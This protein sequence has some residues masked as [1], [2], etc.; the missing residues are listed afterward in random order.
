M[1]NTK[2]KFTS[3]CSTNGEVF[4]SI[5]QAIATTE[6]CFKDICQ[7]NTI[8]IEQVYEISKQDFDALNERNAKFGGKATY[9]DGVRVEETET[10]ND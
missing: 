4:L 9:H 1:E 7:P 6:D 2:C 3:T 10:E 5:S 8:T